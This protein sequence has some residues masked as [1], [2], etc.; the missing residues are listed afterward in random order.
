MAFS[1]KLRRR[2]ADTGGTDPS[3]PG[4]VLRRRRSTSAGHA[5]AAGPVGSGGT[6]ARSGSAGSLRPAVPPPASRRTADLVSPLAARPRPTPPARPGESPARRRGA[7]GEGNA[8]PLP[9]R[10]PVQPVDTRAGESDLDDIAAM[11][12]YLRR[13]DG[14][15]SAS[16]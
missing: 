16:A 1:R 5:A 12:D 10:R 8:Q 13:G 6:A 9:H 15:G 14:P 11:M 3:E 2:R 7:P 4:G